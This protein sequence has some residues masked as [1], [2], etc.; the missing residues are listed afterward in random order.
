MPELADLVMNFRS[1]GEAG[2][3]G[4]LKAV[5]GEIKQT[6]KDA[7][8]AGLSFAGMGK[9]MLAG[10]AVVGVAAAAIGVGL[11]HIGD[12][13]DAM[14]DSIAIATGAS[15]NALKTLTNDAMTVFKAVPTTM[16]AAGNAIAQLS[17]KTGDSGKVLDKLA[18]SEL[19]LSRITGTDL[20]Q[21]ITASAAIFN[22]WGVTAKNQVGV[23]DQIF[24]ASQKTG[25]GVD[26][27]MGQVQQFAPTL[28]QMGLTAG[29]SATLLGNLDKSGVNAGLVLRGLNTEIAKSAKA[30]VDAKTGITNTVTAIQNAGSAADATAIAVKAFGTRAGP[31]LAQAILSGKLSV[32]DLT[33][34][35]DGSGKSILDQAKAT[36]DL[37]ENWTLFRNNVEAALV[38][39]GSFVFQGAN[40]VIPYLTKGA[41]AIGSFGKK[42]GEAFNPGKKISDIVK[43]MP[44]P[45]QDVTRGVLTVADGFGDLVQRWQSKGFDGMVQILPDR[46]KQ[47][48]QGFG[49]IAGSVGHAAI[50][51]VV[52]TAV[53]EIKGWLADH[54][55]DIWS[56]IKSIIGWST[57]SFLQ[58]AA[59]TIDATVSLVT[60]ISTGL[61]DWVKGQL[62]PSHAT[63]DGTGG[64]DGANLPPITLGDVI[65]Q[66][67]VRFDADFSDWD[68]DITSALGLDSTKQQ[69][70]DAEAAGETLGAAVAQKVKDGITKGIS[71]GGDDKS[72]S[73]KQKSGGGGGVFADIKKILVWEPPFARGEQP[74]VID[75]A[76]AW[77]EGLGSG[78]HN[79]V[80]GGILKGLN[81]SDN[82]V[83]KVGGGVFAGGEG[84]ASGGLAGWLNTMGDTF[85]Q[86]IA[87]FFTGIPDA[88][89]SAV[90]TIGDIDIP[91][92]GLP[93]WIKDPIGALFGGGSD[94]G[95]S[96][97][98]VGGGAFAGGVA[99][100]PAA[101][102]ASFFTDLPGKVTGLVKDLKIDIPH[103]SLPGWV[104]DL[105]DWLNTPFQN[106]VGA[107]T[108]WAQAIN[109]A[110]DKVTG[111]LGRTHNTPTPKVGSDFG[112]SGSGGVTGSADTGNGL[113]NF[114]PGDTN[115]TSTDITP[116]HLQSVIDPPDL[117]KFT[118]GVGEA[119]KG[120]KA[121]FEADTGPVAVAFTE[122]EGWGDTWSKATFN[123]TFGA[124]NGPAAIAYTDA[125]G[126][127][128]TWGNAVFTARFSIDTS[129]LAVAEQAALS[130]VAFIDS[131]MPHSPAKRGPLK[132]LP[133][134]GALFEGIGPA[135][136]KAVNIV[137]GHAALIAGAFGASVQARALGGAGGAPVVINHYNLNGV[138]G[139]GAIKEVNRMV[140]RGVGTQIKQRNSSRSYAG[141]KL[142]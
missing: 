34:S 86:P 114:S 53:P 33:G 23:L 136:D 2:T 15:G 17:A 47:I 56:G 48:A 90:G 26:V 116:V 103:P 74:S 108:A 78:I 106:L 35:I 127:G 10:A 12:K 137:S 43:G 70:D 98:K 124:D 66:A 117:P 31:Q 128:D 95:G 88:I 69:Q 79:A 16:D 72:D 102:I 28:Q 24:S 129:G 50:S 123:A 68:N 76:L 119:L 57:D 55:D 84:G 109:D 115:N 120:Y 1:Q 19:E 46:L 94:G 71:G 93:D 64:P 101:E 41:S 63:G 21:N 32:D 37:S 42:L 140:R 138:N 134:W 25:T 91:M 45:L 118:Q 100:D 142:P 29:Q 141:A 58:A 105:G 122:V 80:V 92:P 110:W 9:G 130:A 131:I 13:A 4:A 75:D 97:P 14:S 51:F 77:S 65:A 121:T 73:G 62:F 96:V 112:T 59:V 52:D 139:D 38:P 49:E 125:Y 30:G 60:N 82:G 67:T 11:F 135:G 107:L 99:T 133:R 6:E 27:L 3:I 89:T 44:R 61:Y 83:P 7:K 18:E 113:P 8:S 40:K 39:L 36:Y 104:S 111:A 85:I 20:N 22:Q 81:G 126:W 54:K 87:D 132:R 5:D